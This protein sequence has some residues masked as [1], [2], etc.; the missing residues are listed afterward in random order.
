MSLIVYIAY[1]YSSYLKQTIGNL[2]TNIHFILS[3]CIL[4][5]SALLLWQAPLS[6]SKGCTLLQLPEQ[7]SAVFF[8]GYLQAI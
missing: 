4:S 7:V 1:R 6:D 5:A 3:A 2:F 8:M